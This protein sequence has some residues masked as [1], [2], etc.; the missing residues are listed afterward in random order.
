MW[1][2]FSVCN[3]D[4]CTVTMVY[5]NLPLTPTALLPLH[6]S[7][8]RMDVPEYLCLKFPWPTG[9]SKLWQAVITMVFTLLGCALS[10][11]PLTCLFQHLT[12][13]LEEGRELSFLL[14][15]G[16]QGKCWGYIGGGLLFLIFR[17]KKNLA[18]KYTELRCLCFIIFKVF[19]QLQFYERAVSVEKC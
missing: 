12:N 6:L 4:I 10:N 18:C 13:T 8:P 1:S 9:I 2:G 19:R 11:N 3:R 17:F 16:K 14:L 15:R 5:W 7:A